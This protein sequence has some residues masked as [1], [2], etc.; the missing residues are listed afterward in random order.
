MNF[1]R[2]AEWIANQLYGGVLPRYPAVMV[3]ALLGTI[4]DVELPAVP[5]A[6]LQEAKR[7]WA[8]C[9]FLA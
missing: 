9:L 1:D 3:N 4:P 7:R 6:A 2:L 5:T 8:D